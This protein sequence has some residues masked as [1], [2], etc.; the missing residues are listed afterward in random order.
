VRL[1]IYLASA[2]AFALAA[3]CAQT[4]RNGRRGTRRKSNGVIHV[5]DTVLIPS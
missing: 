1:K 4:K 2:A 5:V 3:E